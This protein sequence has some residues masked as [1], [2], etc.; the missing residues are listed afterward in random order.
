MTFPSHIVGLRWP[1]TRWF[2]TKFGAKKPP[3]WLGWR[4][5]CPIHGLSR[6]SSSVNT[7]IRVSRISNPKYRTRLISMIPRR[8]ASDGSSQSERAEREVSYYIYIFFTLSVPGEDKTQITNNAGQDSQ[9]APVTTSSIF[10]FLLTSHF[11]TSSCEIPSLWNR[12][13]K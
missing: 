1:R 9:V 12:D 3:C 11:S 10:V 4:G 5:R 2:Q 8:A 13:Y 6:E 7:I